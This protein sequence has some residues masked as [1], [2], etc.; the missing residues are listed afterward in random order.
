[1]TT[2]LTLLPAA[3]ALLTACPASPQPGGGFAITVGGRTTRAATIEAALAAAR[4]Q[5]ARGPVTVTFP[6]G[7]VRLTAPIALD[8]RDSGTVLRAAP[9]GTTLSGAIVVA[10]A[11]ATR[12]DDSRVGALA[13]FKVGDP[14]PPATPQLFAG[15]ERLRPASWPAA[16]YRTGWHVE[17]TAAGPILRPVGAPLPPIAGP[18]LVSGYFGPGWAWDAIPARVTDGGLLLARTPEFGIAD[19]ARLRVGGALPLAPGRYAPDSGGAHLLPANAPIELARTPTLLTL[20]GARDVRVEGLGFERTTGTAIRIDESSDV[21]LADCRIRQTGDRA[22]EVTGGHGVTIDRCRIGETGGTAIFVSAGRRAEL[23]PSGDAIT[24]TTVTHWGQALPTAPGLVVWG[25][26]TSVRGNRIAGGGG[27]AIQLQ[28]ND[29]RVEGN[30]I[31]WAVCEAED[32]GAVYLGRDWTGRGTVIGDNYVHDIGDGRDAQIAGVYLDD[33]ASGT[34][35]A[36]NAFVQLPF[37]VILGGGRDNAVTAN[38]FAALSKAAVMFDARGTTWAKALTE[39]GGALRERLAA[40]P[41]RN[42]LWRARYPQ[43]AAL[44]DDRAA[45]PVGNVMAGNARID[46]QPLWAL[47]PGYA[48]DVRDDRVLQPSAA[49]RVVLDSDDRERAWPVLA[50]LGGLD[51]DQPWRR[52]PPTG[53]TAC[54]R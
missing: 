39:P 24:A 28:G 10:P 45:E 50:R 48:L 4:A 16:G 36:R 6:A 32:A 54:P 8:A 11:G 35:V 34:E 44:P 21:R 47:T 12:L 52:T 38:L 9:E 27:A 7:L 51:P 46:S 33:L 20:A 17:Q 1:M 15:D 29:H 53:V 25:V 3:L 26:G 30:E 13:G 5:H 31:A 40:M 41:Y 2:R 43:L 37:G 14:A 18:V 23:E 42:A 49:E 19:T 22:I